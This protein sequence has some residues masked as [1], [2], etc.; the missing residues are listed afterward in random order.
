[1]N[2]FNPIFR[3]ES[4]HLVICQGVLHHTSDPYL[5]F[6]TIGKLVKKGGYIIIGLYNKYGRLITDTRRWIF[7]ITGDKFKFLDPRLRNIDRGEA[8]RVSWFKDQ[9]KHPHE[10]KHTIGEILKWFEQNNFEFVNAIPKVR[11]FSPLKINENL[12]QKNR[13]GNFIEH[14]IV[15]LSSILGGYKEGGLFIMIGKKKD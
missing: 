3:E 5:G 10:S 9:Y 12:F 14:L 2:L 11:P 6:K 4:F 13:K 8:K 7:T 15:Q 1:M